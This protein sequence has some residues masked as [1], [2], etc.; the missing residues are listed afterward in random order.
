MVAEC[1][2][3]ERGFSSATAAVELQVLLPDGLLVSV[4]GT[5]GNAWGVLD[6]GGA[7]A[8]A[9]LPGGTLVDLVAGAAA[10]LPESGGGP[11]RPDGLLHIQLPDGQTVR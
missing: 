4:T 1:Q 9:V 7:L 10:V 6:S 8:K 3:T 11:M 2:R 5:E